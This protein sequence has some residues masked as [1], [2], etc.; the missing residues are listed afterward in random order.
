MASGAGTPNEL[1]AQRKSHWLDRWK[2]RD[3]ARRSKR[4]NTVPRPVE[5]DEPGQERRPSDL[6]HGLPLSQNRSM[7]GLK[8]LLVH[9]ARGRFPGG[10]RITALRW[11]SHLR[12]LG[13]RV[14]LRSGYD[15]QG[16]TDG[17][18]SDLL[19]ALHAKKC[20]SDV[21][22]FR[23]AHP[24]KPILVGLAGTDVYGDDTDFGVL[25][26]VLSSATRSIALQAETLSDLPADLREKT[27][28]IHQSIALPSDLCREPAPGFQVALIAHL[29]E[30]KDP[31][32]GARAS[33]LLPA[34]SR[35][36][37][38]HIG[39]ALD[40]VSKAEASAEAKQNPRYS[41][42]G[43]KTR[44]EVLQTLAASRLT[45]S[46]SRHEG[47]ANAISEAI[48]VGTAVLATN[49]PGNTGLLGTDYPGLFPVGDAKA[50]ADLLLRTES[51]A[52]FLAELEAAVAARAWMFEPSRER[53]AWKELLAEIT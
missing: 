35:V 11:A 15:A 45:I 34:K 3:R 36:H 30:V 1:D 25:D 53:Q 16:E 38:V 31:L 17:H 32:L 8:I 51:D 52:E 27:R 50:L 26:E 33:R 22:A 2:G 19:I 29:R 21:L 23:R 46:T 14:R 48:V 49:I 40:E 39:R 6:A 7:V 9:P 44:C 20:G 5:N 12:A 4:L 24:S 10:N 41:W 28:V 18:E 43:E 47:G 37:V 13:H 42:L